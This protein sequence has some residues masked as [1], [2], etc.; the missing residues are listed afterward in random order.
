VVA[1]TRRTTGKRRAFLG[2]P[3]GYEHVGFY[4]KGQLMG[5]TFLSLNFH[6]IF[7]TKHRAP[8]ISAEWRS[9]LHE[10]LGGAINGQGGRSQGVGG[11]ED[12]VHLL[13]AL[14]ATHCLADFMRE[15]KRQSSI[16]VHETIG[17]LDFNWQE[18][19]AAFTVS[20]PAIPGVQSYIANQ[21]QHHRQQSSRAELEALLKQAGIDFD[22]RHLE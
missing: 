8:Q 19:Y 15:I 2:I 14:K 17:Q 21:E 20:P 11:V 18:G 12:H 10:Y 7:A 22:P 1:A 5:S 3:K 4:L 16:W 9:R 6:I 13:V